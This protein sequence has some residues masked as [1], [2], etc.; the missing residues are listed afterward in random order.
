[1]SGRPAVRAWVR[2]AVRARD[3]TNFPARVRQP[4]P[5]T[6]KLPQ[7]VHETVIT[8]SMHCQEPY[9]HINVKTH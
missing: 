1:M 4:G 9:R 5:R 3:C 7:R 8:T 2:P 6:A